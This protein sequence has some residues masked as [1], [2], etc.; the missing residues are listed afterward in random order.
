[1]KTIIEYI[2][3]G[4]WT[5]PDLKGALQSAI[6]LEFSTIPPYLCAQWSINDDPSGVGSLIQTI[7]VQE[8]H[9]FALAGNILRSIGGSPAVDT[10]SFIPRYPTNTLPSGVDEP[11]A[12]DLLPLSPE[13]VLVFMQIEFP[14]YPPVARQRLA[15]TSSAA[16]D[17]PFGTIGAFY[18]TISEGLNRLKPQFSQTASF[19]GVPTANNNGKIASLEDAL[20]AIELIK[21]EGE[22]TFGNPEEPPTDQG[23]PGDPPAFAHYYTFKSI[24]V[25]RELAQQPDGRWAYTGNPITF[26]TTYDFT[27]STQ[28]SS[29]ASAFNQTLRN[30]LNEL[31]A[32]WMDDPSETNQHFSNALNSMYRLQSEGVQLIRQGITPPFQYPGQ[33]ATNH[34]QTMTV[35][36]HQASAEGIE[37]AAKAA[38]QSVPKNFDPAYVQNAI[39]PA[40][41]MAIYNAGE[42]PL[43][44]IS[45]SF[46][47]E[48][49]LP[50]YLWGMLYDSWKPTP[51]EG[52]S[53]FISGYENRGES[54]D[55]KT[56]LRKRIYFSALTPDLYK[57]MYHEKV[58]AFFNGLLAPENARKP[59]MQLYLDA[60]PDL[61][62]DLHVGV[63][64]SDIPD[65]VRKIG[66][67]FNTVFSYQKPTEEIVYE[68]Y[69]TVRAL[70]AQFIDWV[71]ARVDDVKTGKVASP[72]KTFVHYW[73]KN[74]DGHEA[75][76]SPKDVT[77]ECFHNFVALSQWAH[78]IYDIIQ[79]MS[80]D[81]AIKVRAEFER[82][83]SGEFDQPIDSP[84]TPLIRFVMEMFRLFSPNASSLSSLNVKTASKIVRSEHFY[85][86][87]PHKDTS[88][89]PSHWI[90]PEQFDPDRYLKVPT[91]A[92]NDEK[93]LKEAGFAR[94]PFDITSFKV[95]D[96]RDVSLTNSGFG[97]VYGVQDGKP[98]PVC[99]Y[100]GFAPFGFGY[101][102][103]PGE[104]LTEMVFADFLRQIWSK[105]IEFYNLQL[106]GPR[107]V[108]AGP[109]V[110]ADDNYGFKIVGY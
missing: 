42:L 102:R 89:D 106:A 37:A 94:C 57:P 40:Y 29:D 99:D 79:Y 69:M 16:T 68:N 66:A 7:A 109:G 10:P 23:G 33:S 56:N 58:T 1:M 95:Q 72:E 86:S 96:G 100:A 30:T 2:R 12:I 25:G 19:I 48:N 24:Y 6:Q 45:L 70:R 43:P 28:P 87:V 84:F 93:K 5:L 76:F 73:I 85:I 88:F 91:S 108:P 38:L 36:N 35:N 110:V 22:G 74:S 61:Y 101:R 75:Y 17:A 3:E 105:K 97:T 41:L 4:I 64:G 53:V 107:E 49:A 67:S 32:C 65:Y 34:S 31:Q 103:C 77:F 59:F 81:G 83:M 11:M 90:N 18:D 62:W 104:Q 21:E 55:N 60:Y 44:M 9:H 71:N 39:F 26:P 82:V 27:K 8:M 80:D 20:A 15:A 51:S 52:S 46:T 54:P 63:T 47:K 98:M 14:E 78:T 13:Q 92:Q 50:Y